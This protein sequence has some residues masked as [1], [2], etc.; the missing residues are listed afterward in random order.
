MIHFKIKLPCGKLKVKSYRWLGRHE[1][2]KEV[3]MFKGRR[4]LFHLEWKTP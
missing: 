3:P 1:L 2:R 4:N